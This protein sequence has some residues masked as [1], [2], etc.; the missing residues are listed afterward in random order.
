MHSK[1]RTGVYYIFSKSKPAIL[2]AA[3]NKGVQEAKSV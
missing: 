2:G 1:R 3:A